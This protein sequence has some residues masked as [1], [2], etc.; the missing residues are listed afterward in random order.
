MDHK[1]GMI[2][3]GVTGAAVLG[4]ALSMAVGFW[5]PT[6]YLSCFASMWIALGYVALAAALGATRREPGRGGMALTGLAF[7]AMY[8]VT[9]CLVYFA[10]CTTVRMDGGLSPQALALIGYATPG[11]LFFNYDLLGYAFMAL[12]TFFCGFLVR[13][14]V[15]WARPLR[16]MLWLHGAFFLPCLLMPMLPVF[17]GGGDSQAYGTILLEGWC[18]YFLPVCLLALGYFRALGRAKA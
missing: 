16:W 17:A 2:G 14:G 10:Q 5:T 3:A 8:A 7:A 6:L 9:V 18:A 1:L 4:F 13:D 15:R 12:S 11:S